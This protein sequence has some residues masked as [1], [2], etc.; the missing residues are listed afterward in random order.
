M[1]VQHGIKHQGGA[2]EGHEAHDNSVVGV[3]QDEEDAW[4][5]A[6]QP[7][8][9]DDGDCALCGHDAVITQCIEDGDVAIRS[10]GAQKGERGH[11]GA[12]DHYV[13]YVV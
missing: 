11:H 12:A 6:G 9:H 10:N 8:H 7:H 2:K 1:Q 3:V 4:G 13:N 5:D